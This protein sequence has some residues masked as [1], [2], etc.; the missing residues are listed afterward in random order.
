MRQDVSTATVWSVGIP[1]KVKMRFVLEGTEWYD[2]QNAR[3]DSSGLDPA[4]FYHLGCGQDF[5][6]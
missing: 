2:T 1:S 5:S 4:M 6:T 3:F